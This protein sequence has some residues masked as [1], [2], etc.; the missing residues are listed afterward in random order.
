M[1]ELQKFPIEALVAL[2]ERETAI[3]RG[4]IAKYGEIQTDPFT[5]TLKELNR[6]FEQALES[7]VKRFPTY[8]DD[9][10]SALESEVIK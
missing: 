9:R 7:K 3:I 2:V 8:E 1:T 5:P 6:R 10:N 4:D